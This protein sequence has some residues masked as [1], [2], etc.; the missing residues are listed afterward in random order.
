MQEKL[1]KSL[2]LLNSVISGG[3]TGLGTK[4]FKIASAMKGSH[5]DS[6]T[7]LRGRPAY[8]NDPAL[9][10]E[11]NDR[12]MVWAESIGLYEGHIDYLRKCD[13]G[14]YV[15][16]THAFS[17]DRER[18]FLLRSMKVRRKSTCSQIQFLYHF[19]IIYKIRLN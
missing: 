9:G 3:P 14:G 2:N 11:L 12:L 6:D 5:Y 7:E 8:R 16:L 13:F 17:Y 18:L 1:A 15:M 4:S 19:N 10:K